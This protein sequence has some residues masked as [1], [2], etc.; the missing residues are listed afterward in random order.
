MAQSSETDL[1]M[2]GEE[3]GSLYIMPDGRIVALSESAID[4]ITEMGQ[5]QEGLEEQQ[6][7]E[8]D[9]EF[10]PALVKTEAEVVTQIRINEDIL[11]EPDSFDFDSYV[12]TVFNCRSCNFTDGNRNRMTDHVKDAHLYIQAIQEAKVLVQGVQE[13]KVLMGEE[14]DEEEDAYPEQSVN[15][16]SIIVGDMDGSG[17]VEE[18][19]EEHDPD[20]SIILQEDQD[21]LESDRNPISLLSNQSL[22]KSPKLDAKKKCQL[23]EYEA[24][25]HLRLLSCTVKNC[26][27]L[28]KRQEDVD[29]HLR[30]LL[31]LNDY[32]SYCYL[33]CHLEE[34]GGF[35]C[36]EPDCEER[37]EK[38]RELATH[39]WRVHGEDCGMLLCGLCRNY[40]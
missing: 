34:E 8:Q 24:D 18:Q 37:R 11:M 35:R 29:Y 17:C 30:C 33:R 5:Q 28:F 10:S 32:F 38:W 36:C 9:K 25:H 39:L 23:V 4:M 40:R 27:F 14:G 22:K 12:D 31:L 16:I 21:T 3:G 26:G 2:A 15:G 7:L 6:M 20:F 1:R 13:A 19:D